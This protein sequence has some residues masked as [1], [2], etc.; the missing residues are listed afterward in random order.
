MV[1]AAPCRG[2]NRFAIESVKWC[3]KN[4]AIKVHYLHADVTFIVAIE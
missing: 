1:L 2:Q 4:Q 3:S